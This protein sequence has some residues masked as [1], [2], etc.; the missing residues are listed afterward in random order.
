MTENDRKIIEHE[1]R[2]NVVENDI[3][4]L[5]NVVSEI[6]ALA[7]SVERIS[8][9]QTAMLEQQKDIKADVD[10]IKSQPAKD[11]HDFKV[12]AIKEAIK[13]VVALVLG[14]L[15]AWIILQTTG[16]TK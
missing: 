10:E 4:D 16:G 6:H 2:L 13:F 8:S 12:T 9:T 11:A 5:K 14:A 7:L 1:A 3:V 15:V